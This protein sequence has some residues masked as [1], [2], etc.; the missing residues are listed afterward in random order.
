MY[1]EGHAQYTYSGTVQVWRPPSYGMWKHR[2]WHTEYT[3]RVYHMW[4]SLSEERSHLL[5]SKATGVMWWEK[6]WDQNSGE[7]P[8]HLRGRQEVRI[9]CL[10]STGDKQGE[11]AKWRW[12]QWLEWCSNKPRSTK[13]C[14]NGQ[15][16]GERL[17]AGPPSRPSS[18]AE[19]PVCWHWNQKRRR[20]GCLSAPEP[21]SRDKGWIFV[22][23]WLRCR[24]AEKAGC[25]PSKSVLAFPLKLTEGKERVGKE[26]AKKG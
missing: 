24:W 12:R 6:S 4:V 16:P 14:G 13:D 8:R 1:L 11:N 26:P 10:K 5:T 18:F 22:G 9:L 7:H 3:S 15:K 17:G 20:W 23:A 25:V 21:L 19:D 2:T